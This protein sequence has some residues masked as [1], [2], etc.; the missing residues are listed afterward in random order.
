MPKQSSV[1]GIISYADLSDAFVARRC[2]EAMSLWSSEMSQATQTPEE[3]GR[4]KGDQI[5]RKGHDDGRRHIAALRITTHT[6]SPE[7]TD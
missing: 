1:E 4:R 3:T 7:S 2:I 6:F 5:G